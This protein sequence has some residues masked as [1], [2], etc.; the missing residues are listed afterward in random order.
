VEE[1]KKGDEL[2]DADVVL[3]SKGNLHL[4]PPGVRHRLGHD[5]SCDPA[6]VASA[7][8]KLAA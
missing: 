1:K 6:A 3:R 8:A 7:A 5:P 4:L 2:S